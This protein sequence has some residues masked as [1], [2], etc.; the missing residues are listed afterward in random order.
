MTQLKAR[1][2]GFR[3]WKPNSI[4]KRVLG[5]TKMEEKPEAQELSSQVDADEERRKNNVTAT[6]IETPDFTERLLH[7]SS[8][9]KTVRMVGWIL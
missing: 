5:V 2:K 4:L 9:S 7:F 1:I 3:K 8:Y 6:I